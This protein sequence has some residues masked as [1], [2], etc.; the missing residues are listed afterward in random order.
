MQPIIT[1]MSCARAVAIIRSASRR[2]PHFESLMLI[3]STTPASFAN[4]ARDDARLVGDDRQRR[5]LAHEAQPLE[6]V[7]RQ[8]LLDELDAVLREQLDHVERVLRRPCGV[9]VDAKHLVRRRLANDADDLLVA[10][11]PSLI[12]SIGY[13]RRLL[14]LRAQLGLR[15]HADREARERRRGR[16]EPPQ[17]VDRNAESLADEIVERGADGALRRAV[18]APHA[19]HLE[20]DRVERPRVGLARESAR[21]GR[22]RPAA[23][24]GVSP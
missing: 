19:V 1:R 22:A 2:P 17:P 4:V 9:R 21:T 10:V 15:R 13:S 18:A 20:L 12:L 23:V 3:P 11:V 5:A 14:H 6:I 7:R 16:I 8:R 24:S